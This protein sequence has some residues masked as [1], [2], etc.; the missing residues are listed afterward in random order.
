MKNF[1]YYV[2]ILSKEGYVMRNFFKY[3]GI[4]VL[5]LILLL[6]I[7]FL[8]APLILSGI[9]NSYSTQISK[10]I[11]D[12]CGFK[13]KIDDIKI[14]TT[15]KLT[16]GVYAG[17]IEAAMPD[18][19]QF[20]MV[21]NVQGK[22]SLLPLIIRKIEIDMIGADN[23]N[24][25]L[26][27]KKDGKFLLEDF[28]PKAN[29]DKTPEQPEIVS[30][31][32]G[33]KLSNHLPD[34]RVNNYNISFI[35][36]VTDKSYSI[37]GEK[38]SIKDFI[39]NKKIKVYAIGQV[40]LDDRVQF[41]YDLNLYNKVMPDLDLNDL[42]FSASKEET[43]KTQPVSINIISVL[44]NIYYNQFSA[45]ITADLKTSG[46]F[47]DIKINGSAA[48]S[49]M[50]LAVKQKKLPA[51]N[52]DMK[53]SGNKIYMYSKLYS[54]D[55][56]ITELTGDFKTGKSPKIDLN[57]KSNAR[58]NSILRILDSIA[59][60]F[61]YKDLNTL[62]ATGSIDADFTL[63][64]DLKKIESS[65]YLRINPS[66]F[67]YKFY[68]IFVNDVIADIDF[69]NNMVN[70]KDAGL[71]I[72]GHPLK[73]S[74]TLT[75]EAVADINIIADRLQIKGL[76]LALGQVQLL[77]DNDIK[78]GTLT[79]NALLKGRLDRI[80]PTVK[81]SIDNINIKNSPANTSVKLASANV[82]LT[83][84]GKKMSGSVKA[85]NASVI[86]PVA[87]ASMPEAQ[88]TFGNKDIIIDNSDV[89]LNNSKI[90][91]TGKVSDYMSDKLKFTINANG[92]IISSDIKSMIPAD[93]RKDI[94]AKGSLPL[95]ISISGDTN[96]Q[97]IKFSLDANSSN[98][99][100]VLN[101]SQLSGKSVSIKGNVKL[102]GDALKFSDTGI[103][104][105]NEGIV[106]LKGNVSDLYNSQ[107][108]GLK[109]S[110][111]SK[112][113]MEIPGFKK[114]KL[115]AFGDVNVSGMLMNP[116]LS[117]NIQI[118]VINIPDMLISL[119]DMSVSLNGPILKGK[120]TLMKFVSGGIVAENLA[121][122]FSLLNNVFYLKN[123]SGD[124]F[125]GKIKGDVSY[126]IA[127][128]K[129]GVNFSGTEL[130]AEKAIAGAA[131]LKNALSGKLDFNA[132]VT[133]HGTTEA[134]MMKNLKG[135]VAFNVKDGSLGNIGRF[136]NF[137]LADNL[138]SNSIIKA[139]VNSVSALPTVKNTA[140]F[141]T[142]SGNLTFNNGWAKL[143]PIKT[144][145]P[146]MAY[147]ITG[148]YNLLNA[149]A[150]VIILGRISA[151]VVSLLGPLG[152]LSV[153]KLTSY[154]PKFGTLTG[155]IINA[156]TSD[157]KN[158]NIAAIP[159]LSSGNTNYKDFKVVFNGGVETNSS[160]KSFKWLSKC[161]T[162]ALEQPTVKEQVQ[163]TKQAV[164]DAV[165]QKIDDINAKREAQKQSAQEA[166]QQMKDA[167]QGLK[168]LFKNNNN[169]ETVET[170][171]VSN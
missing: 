37:S 146:S 170:N 15:P 147:Y 55:N 50:G 40:M 56:E 82:D 122:D 131:G 29:E 38:F 104:A 6:Y 106:Y 115:D 96:S 70:I 28:I 119:N 19:Q 107:K 126:N 69:S 5:S 46:T 52:I 125:E 9:A 7:L 142:I 11:E 91:V 148:Q 51:S 108:L 53:F 66:S 72:L 79:L 156:V 23:I 89:Y 3:L 164:Q 128:G 86:N 17:H 59:E 127:N 124:A 152:D 24:L 61:G 93:L 165:Q 31:P 151:E 141:K 90:A 102:A 84:D 134:E 75:P 74:G 30:L 116:H 22:I 36:A 42:I 100:S 171:E 112:I 57:C 60:S 87:T 18:G 64:S 150:N 139:A 149:T 113:S 159:Q 80:V 143:N 163:Q 97:D 32:F 120:G 160:V 12:S 138:Q 16:A 27:V 92:N 158:E 153:S 63:K 111:P 121:A 135:K 103:F 109:I 25:N 71:S 78:S 155:N 101:V 130:N 39:L 157:P 45:N 73:I 67:S 54:A 44:K 21:D 95:A 140:E 161:D 166:N 34:I 14:L 105:N 168:N 76:L 4:T 13:L 43:A 94:A 81:L 136:E 35:D 10:I 123:I 47:D 144:S 2:T 167:V 77:K 48:V 98:Y 154:I 65:G 1:L 137:L 62:T 49:E 85:S 114:S 99:V 83:T 118:P 145:G 26:K 8:A 129:I 110:L 169:Q 133:L 33:L 58:F 162:S 117:G 68:N 20:L 88:I 132:D 41:N